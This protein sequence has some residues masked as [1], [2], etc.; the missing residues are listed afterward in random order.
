M[1]KDLQTLAGGYHRSF[2]FWYQQAQLL[3]PDVHEIRY[4]SFVTHLSRKSGLS[5]HFCSCPGTN[6]CWRRA[7]TRVTRG[8]SAA[9]SYAQVVQPVYSSSIGR[10]RPYARHFTEVIPLVRPL[11]ERWEYEA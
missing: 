8:S 9:P 11:L 3:N 5:A 1:C 2:D 10:W 4:E 6:E 7:S